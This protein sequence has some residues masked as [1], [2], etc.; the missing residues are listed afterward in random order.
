MQCKHFFPFLHFC[1]IIFKAPF[2]VKYLLKVFENHIFKLLF[3]GLGSCF[4]ECSPAPPPQ[5]SYENN[6]HV[7]LQ[8]FYF[9]PNLCK[10]SIQ[11]YISC[12]T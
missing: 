9:S 12:R 6:S 11:F 10:I 5:L 8:R 4:R 3:C 7:L 2:L 1:F